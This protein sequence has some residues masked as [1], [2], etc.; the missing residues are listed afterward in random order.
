MAT[1]LVVR[2]ADRRLSWLGSP[3]LALQLTVPILKP[4][5]DKRAFL[6]P[7]I[8]LSLP[9]CA[10]NVSYPQLHK[11]TSTL[12]F[13]AEEFVSR[14]FHLRSAILIVNSNNIQL[15]LK[16]YQDYRRVLQH[17]FNC[18]CSAPID[19]SQLRLLQRRS[20]GS[21]MATIC[22]IHTQKVRRRHRR[23]QHQVDLRGRSLA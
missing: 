10:S 23:C 2:I 5:V 22:F 20:Q 13:V 8:H 1:R 12:S 16:I 14:D 4:Q 15:S 6:M 19:K 11:E 3:H 21:G 18:I 9:P 7:I 17:H